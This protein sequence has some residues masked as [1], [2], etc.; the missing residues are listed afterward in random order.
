MKQL[1]VKFT[2]NVG[3]FP[4]NLKSVKNNL[5]YSFLLYIDGLIKSVSLNRKIIKF[6]GV[7]F[8]GCLLFCTFRG[9]SFGVL[10]PKF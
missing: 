5:F 3:Y 10:W 9:T 1:E 7:V 8:C 4:S 2:K 6:T